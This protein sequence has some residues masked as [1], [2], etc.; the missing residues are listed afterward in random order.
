MGLHR[1]SKLLMLLL[2]LTAGVDGRM[3]QRWQAL[4]RWCGLFKPPTMFTTLRALLPKLQ[5][6]NHYM[7]KIVVFASAPLTDSLKADL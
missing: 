6:T 4:A 2:W 1:Y 5:E 3:K 7:N